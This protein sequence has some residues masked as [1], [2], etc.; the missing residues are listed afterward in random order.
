M[1][2]GWRLLDGEIREKNWF[3]PPIFHRSSSV[4]LYD[5][6]IDS[7]DPDNGPWTCISNAFLEVLMIQQVDVSTIRP[8][9]MVF[10]DFFLTEDQ[11]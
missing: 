11:F 3:L 2:K 6:Y 1:A 9:K 8:S 4:I 10:P 5:S 7:P